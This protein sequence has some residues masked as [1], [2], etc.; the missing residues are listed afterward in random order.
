MTQDHDAQ[1][2]RDPIN[3]DT[4]EKLRMLGVHLNRVQQLPEAGQLWRGAWGQDSQ[5]QLILLV[6][7]EWAHVA[8]VTVDVAYADNFTAVLRGANS[9]LPVPAAVFAGLTTPVPLF[10]LD[11]HLGD[12]SPEAVSAL[13][14]LRLANLRG[15]TPE[16]SLETGSHDASIVDPRREFRNDL[17]DTLGQL[18]AADLASL[19]QPGSIDI[20][21]ELGARGVNVTDL[22]T[23]LN[24]DLAES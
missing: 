17:A 2:L 23:L 14:K 12:V 1:D 11:L 3:P 20:D 10:T 13:N 16:S 4:I 7:D 19:S 9:P 21:E 5:L 6:E 22:K 24:V 18:A 15:E 8:P